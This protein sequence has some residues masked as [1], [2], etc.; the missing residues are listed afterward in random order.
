M[1][2]MRVSGEPWTEDGLLGGHLGVSLLLED[3]RTNPDVGEGGP[4]AG[5]SGR[6]KHR[7]APGSG[8]WAS[9]EVLGVRGECVRER[10]QASWLWHELSLC[11]DGGVGL[12]LFYP[13]GLPSFTRGDRDLITGT[14]SP[15]G[16]TLVPTALARSVM[17]SESWSS[18]RSPS[19]LLDSGEPQSQGC[20][21]NSRMC[22]ERGLRLWL[23]RGRRVLSSG[24]KR[25]S[26]GFSRSLASLPPVSLNAKHLYIPRPRWVSLPSASNT[27]SS[28]HG[29]IF[30]HT[31]TC[32]LISAMACSLLKWNLMWCG[33]HLISE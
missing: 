1:R 22:S 25:L 2:V 13:L 7:R 17:V 15:M 3:Q 32:S 33:F 29:W 31:V 26:H 28:F 30:K 12:H 14:S 18:A 24:G 16:F 10:Q 27:I 19:G 5:D 11:K 4:T 9:R 21:S 6:K 23:W 8:E 20:H